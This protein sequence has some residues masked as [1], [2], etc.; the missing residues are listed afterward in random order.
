M[1]DIIIVL[2]R[3]DVGEGGIRLTVFFTVYFIFPKPILTLTNIGKD[4]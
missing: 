1:V 4:D 2:R 3:Y